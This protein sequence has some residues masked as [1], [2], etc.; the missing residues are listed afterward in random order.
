M[1]R[2]LVFFARVG[3]LVMFTPVIRHL[4]RDGELDLLVRPWGRPLLTGQP[5]VAEIHTLGNPNRSGLLARLIDGKERRQVEDA[6]RARAYDE[7][8]T[9]KGETAVVQAWIDRFA[10][11]AVRRF[12]SR[13]L[14]DAPRH[15]VDANRRALEFGGFSTDGFDPTPRLVPA[16]QRLQAARARL[17]PLGRRV[18]ALQAGS[19]LTHRWLRRQPNL[20][21]LTPAQWSTLIDHLFTCDTADAAVLHGSAP[22]GR[23]ARAIRAALPARWR[24]R[25][26]DWTGQV[27][28]GDLPAV[29]AASHATISVDTGPAHIAAAVGCPLMVFFGPTDPAVFAPR[30][31]GRIEVVLGSA[32]CQFCHGT[33]QFKR[34]RANICLSH[35]K[36]DV[37]TTAWKRLMG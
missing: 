21:G 17:A 31:P 28:L 26:H 4:A 34:C 13:A 35:L 29:L 9:F 24:E 16:A 3:D 33:P 32:P 20:K 8:V 5:G 30:G 15:Q 1:R 10:G 14:P 2:L 11:T 25:V 27:T 23:E 7:I 37:L 22:E 12:V 36:P 19:S 6:L 18:V